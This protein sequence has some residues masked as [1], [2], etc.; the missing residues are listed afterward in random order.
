MAALQ[1]LR[2]SLEADGGSAGHGVGGE[3]GDGSHLDMQGSELRF[4]AAFGFEGNGHAVASFLFFSGN[5]AGNYALS[6]SGNAGAGIVGALFPGQVVDQVELGHGFAGLVVE[7]VGAGNGLG[8]LGGS[9]DALRVAQ[10]IGGGG[11][12]YGVHER[13]LVFIRVAAQDLLQF[14]DGLAF[15]EGLDIVKIGG[16]LHIRPGALHVQ[17]VQVAVDAL[18]PQ[19]HAFRIILAKGTVAVG[20]ADGG[21]VFP[22]ADELEFV[23]LRGLDHVVL[24]RH[25]DQSRQ[26]RRSRARRIRPDPLPLRLPLWLRRRTS[27]AGRT[28]AAL[29]VSS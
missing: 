20:D 3:Q 27:A 25:G 24:Q 7:G 21:Q 11:A 22:A 19:H 9:Q 2:G 23:D 15:D 18:G 6:V 16:D 1:L 8:G 14:G 13:S 29:R 12:G 26:R 5:G 4:I 17:A 10:G 28:A